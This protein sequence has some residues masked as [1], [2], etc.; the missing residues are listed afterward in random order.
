MRLY[1]EINKIKKVSNIDAYLY[2][3]LKRYNFTQW[4][5][6]VDL[7]D[8]QT[9]KEVVSKTHRLLKNREYLILTKKVGLQEISTLINSSKEEIKISAG[10]IIFSKADKI[11]KKN[12]Y[13]I[14]LDSKKLKF[15]LKVR[16]VVSGD[17]FYPFGMDGKKKVSKYLKDQ[18]ISKYDK[19][20]TL[21]LETS[22]NEIVWLI[23]MRLDHRF[24][25]TDKTKEILKIELIP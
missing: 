7:L 4:D 12:P 16:N 15:P 18:K 9:G 22:K 10:T 6:I 25:V 17:Y 1:F 14:F 24:S 8:S 11:D 3:L 5:D 23:G 20:K 2:E 21:I 13:S 19:E